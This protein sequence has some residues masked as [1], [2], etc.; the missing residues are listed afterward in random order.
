[1]ITSLLS[2]LLAAGCSGE[3]AEEGSD[4]KT[5]LKYLTLDLGTSV[6]MKLVRVEAG[7]FMM[8]SDK[9]RPDEKPVRSVT[10][11]Q[12]FYMGVCEVTQ[13]Q[14]QA[15]MG[16]ESKPAAGSGRREGMLWG[17]EAYA[18]SGDDNAANYISWEDA[19]RF[20]KALSKKTGRKVALP[21]EAQWEYACRAG[22]RTVY[23]FGDDASR[24]GDYAWYRDNAYGKKEKYPH[25]VGRKKANA[26]GLHDMHGNVWEW[27]TDW[28]ADS[29]AKAKTA[30]PKGPAGG[31]YRVLRGGS[32]YSTPQVCRAAYRP[33]NSP[34]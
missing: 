12:P 10:I 18:Q 11:S 19:G 23:G 31:K 33:G 2:L 1:V 5:S 28:Y 21:T 22:S 34:G 9:G 14:W 26:W 17:G 30:D 20:C 25:A 27:C 7:E 3:R 15:V 32:W 4:A 8:G 24:L 29:Y 16:T 13:A 6:T